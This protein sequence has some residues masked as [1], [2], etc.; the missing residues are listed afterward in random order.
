MESRLNLSNS[1]PS[2]VVPTKNTPNTSTNVNSLNK[3]LVGLNN[4]TAQFNSPFWFPC[5]NC[6]ELTKR[7]TDVEKQFQIYLKTNNRFTC[8]GNN[9]CLA[10][11]RVKPLD[12]IEI[13]EITDIYECKTCTSNPSFHCKKCGNFSN[14]IKMKCSYEC[15]D[16]K[17][18]EYQCSNC[19]NLIWKYSNCKE[20]ITIT[21]NLNK[22]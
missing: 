12:C 14:L 2:F 1:Y 7:M 6:K 22:K 5:S 13:I 15:N 8:C 21:K 11:I 16:M 9:K 18:W 20:Y 19:T 4:N 17:C 3:N 10:D